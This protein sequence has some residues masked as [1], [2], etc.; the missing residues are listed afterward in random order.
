M[1]FLMTMPSRG[2]A[3][4]RP[5]GVESYNNSNSSLAGIPNMSS[6][7][8]VSSQFSTRV[9]ASRRCPSGYKYIVIRIYIVSK[10]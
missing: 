4:L 1:I 6:A 3:I 2:F 9:I 8:Y 5:I 7:Q 10:I